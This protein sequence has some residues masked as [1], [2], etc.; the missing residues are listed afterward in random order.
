MGR[1]TLINIIG[2][3]DVEE[4]RESAPTCSG[5][6]PE[7]IEWERKLNRFGRR[8]A[9][10]RPSPIG[11]GQG[12]YM[13]AVAEQVG[14]DDLL[15]GIETFSQRSLAH[16]GGEWTV[17]HVH[18]KPSGRERRIM[19]WWRRPFWRDLCLVPH[20]GRIGLEAF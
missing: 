8:R 13:S 11:T 16:G 12:V 17:K 3:E 15:R 18:E 7:G 9:S 2:R 6:S 5:R 1:V 4:K 19:R 10:R 20:R 14:A